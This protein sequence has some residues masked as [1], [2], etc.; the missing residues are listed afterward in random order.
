MLERGGSIWQAEEEEE[1]FLKSCHHHHQKSFLLLYL[2]QGPTI[3]AHHNPCSHCKPKIPFLLLPQTH[4][5]YYYYYNYWCTVISQVP[6]GLASQIYRNGVCLCPCFFSILELSC[7]PTHLSTNQ[8]WC[9]STELQGN[10]LW[11]NLQEPYDDVVVYLWAHHHHCHHHHHHH[12]AASSKLQWFCCS[13]LSTRLSHQDWEL[14][15]WLEIFGLLQE[16]QLGY[17]ALLLLLLVSSA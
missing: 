7:Q 6:C 12:H 16:W 13:I 10:D 3:P 4:Y 5:Y 11:V 15:H 14:M 17:D 9:S 2:A 8:Q 1:G